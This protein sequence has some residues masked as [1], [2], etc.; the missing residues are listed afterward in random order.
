[1]SNVTLGNLVSVSE[2]AERLGISD[3]LVLRYI[4]EKRILAEKVGRIWLI[5]S[6]SLDDF[7]SRPR[8]PGNPNFKRLQNA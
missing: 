5:D 4:S 8:R 2:A 6:E 1:M 7:A 3:V